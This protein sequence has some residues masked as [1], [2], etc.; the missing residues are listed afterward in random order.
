MNE[1]NNHTQDEVPDTTSRRTLIS[2]IWVFLAAVGILEI[3]WIAGSLLRARKDNPFRKKDADIL[4]EAGSIDQ[5]RPGDV[6]AVPQGK[7]Y[8]VCL[9]NGS[10]MAV[11]RTCTHLGCSVPWDEEKKQFVCPCHGSSFD[12]RG[13]VLTAPA[14]RPLD[15]YPLR[16]ENGRIKVNA[17]TPLKREHFDPSQAMQS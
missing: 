1:D 8:L 2:R 15:Y 3:G 11:S 14:T 6:K 9:E 10:F 13:V 5:F 4:I 7:F 12:R 16:I 17:A